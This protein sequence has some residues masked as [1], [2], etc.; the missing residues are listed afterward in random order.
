MEKQT[1][2]E[3]LGQLERQRRNAQS[4]A[5]FALKHRHATEGAGFEMET[6]KKRLAMFEENSCR[7]KI[8]ERNGHSC[9]PA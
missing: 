7:F 9:L 5:I 2:N 8:P 3:Q 1:I 4:S 6:A